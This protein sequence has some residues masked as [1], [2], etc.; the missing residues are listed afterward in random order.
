MIDGGS[1]RKKVERRF[2]SGCSGGSQS[3]SIPRLA[4]ACG[5]RESA[6]AF[7]QRAAVR[8]RCKHAGNIIPRR[9]LFTRQRR[10]L[11]YSWN[12]LPVGSRR[13]IARPCLQS[14]SMVPI[15]Y[16]VLHALT[17]PVSVFLSLDAWPAPSSHTH[18]LSSRGPLRRGH[19]ILHHFVPEETLWLAVLFNEIPFHSFVGRIG[20]SISTHA[21]SCPRQRVLSR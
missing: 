20:A 12:K 9:S 18:A 10:T 3:I 2:S 4:V 15:V 17:L 13:P 8:R 5:G 6:R 16:P 11:K 21:D 1:E 7:F 14:L 19:D